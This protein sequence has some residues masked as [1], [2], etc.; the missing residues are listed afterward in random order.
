MATFRYTT[1]I[2]RLFSSGSRS[3]PPL[4]RHLFARSGRTLLALLAG[5]GLAL[6]AGCPS[7]TPPAE[8]RPVALDTL[9]GA[10]EDSL[11]DL[12]AAIERQ[13]ALPSPPGEWAGWCAEV[14]SRGEPLRTWLSRRF[15]ALELVDE[16]RPEGLVTGY[17]E[18]VIRGSLKRESARQVPIRARPADLLVIDLASVEPKLKGLRLRGRVDGQRVVPYFDRA[19][20]ARRPLVD[21]EILGWADD[22]V[23]LFFVEIQGSGRVALRDGSQLRIGYADQ[24]GHPYRAIGRTLIDRGALQADAV[25]APAIKDW[26]RGNPASAP[27][28]MNT[29]PSQVFFRVLPGQPEPGAGPPGA[30]AV[31]LTPMRSVAVDRRE[32]PLGSLLFVSTTDPLSGAPISRFMV[33]Q[34]TGGAIVGRKRLDLFWGSGPQA[35]QAAGRMKAPARI[36]RLVPAEGAGDSEVGN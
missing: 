9:P 21:D 24:N 23:D 17:Y 19:S 33:A 14:A 4:C 28:V 30:M 13:C 27:G 8:P 16:A 11:D 36:W 18:P 7:V 2:V 20:I 35:E 6:L 5:A 26:L 25:S 31:P 12:A 22:A 29:N 15:R 32:I 34:D 1:H 10:L 3:G